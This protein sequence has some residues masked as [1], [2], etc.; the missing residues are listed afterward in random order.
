MLGLGQRN[1]FDT[2]AAETPEPVCHNW[3]LD[4][5]MEMAIDAEELIVGPFSEVVE[6][7]RQAVVASGADPAAVAVER[8]NGYHDEGGF[9]SDRMTRAGRAVVRE[10]ERA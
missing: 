8:G 1:E 10:G 5:H 7:G 2:I 4:S 3:L 9:V 6:R